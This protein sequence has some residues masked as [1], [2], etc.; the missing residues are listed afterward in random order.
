METETDIKT[1]STLDIRAQRFYLQALARQLL[2]DHRVACCLRR[3]LPN[4]RS[5][6]IWRSP[7][8]CRAHYRNLMTCSCLWICAVCAAKISEHRK[9]EIDRAVIGMTA[10]GYRPILATYTMRHS[11]T[12]SLHQ[13]LYDLVEAYKA[14]T[15]GGGW[16]SLREKYEVR[17]YIRTLELT[18]GENGWHP[19][20]HVLMFC[21]E[22][23]E[24]LASELSERWMAILKTVGRDGK[25]DVACDVRMSNDAIGDYISK[26][27]HRPVDLVAT[28]QRY[29]SMQSEIAKSTSKK[30]RG[31]H[32][33]PF[34]ILYDSGAVGIDPDYVTR[35]RALFREYERETKGRR[36][37]EWSRIPD[38]RRV[39]TIVPLSD[40]DLQ[41]K[42]DHDSILL[43]KLTV[44][45]WHIVLRNAAVASLLSIADSGNVSELYEFLEDIG[46]GHV[47]VGE[48]MI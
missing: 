32:R 42:F 43:A 6:E 24:T 4:K 35:S 39:C 17:G 12:D 44:E 31:D 2:P 46:A 25:R 9:V 10:L 18:H 20:L 14:Q 8:R 41:L 40:E 26:F 7:T 19:H 45:Q 11:A 1:L 23:V 27:G 34:E 22:Q 13:T 30:A 16:Q 5:V 48:H 29:W 15:S 36:Q 21:D 28:Q 3:L 37:L 33:N 47:L 38:L